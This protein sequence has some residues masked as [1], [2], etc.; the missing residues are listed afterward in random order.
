VRYCFWIRKNLLDDALQKA[1]NEHAEE[2][3]DEDLGFDAHGD[4]SKKRKTSVAQ[5]LARIRQNKPALFSDEGSLPAIGLQM[6][7]NGHRAIG[8]Y[9]EGRFLLRALSNGEGSGFNASTM[10]KLFNGSVWKRTVVKD[11]SRFSMHHTCLCLCMTFHIEEWHEFLS[12]DGALGMQSRFLTFHSSPRLDKANAVL[13]A[14]VYRGD[15]ADAPLHN[16][17]L[18]GRFV[19][20]LVYTD[21]AHASEKDYI[22]YYFAADALQYFSTH[23]DQQVLEQELSYLQ[24]PK[25]FSHARK[26]KSLPWRLAILL[27]SWRHACFQMG[28]ENAMWSRR[29]SQSVVKVSKT[30]FDYLSL[31][32][33]FLS[34]ASDLLQLLD[35]NSLRQQA[36]QKYPS[37]VSLLEGKS[38]PTASIPDPLSH[39]STNFPQW[40]DA[41]A[42]S[43]RLYCVVGAQW[44]LTSTSSLIVEQNALLRKLHDTE[45]GE[46]LAKDVARNHVINAFTLLHHAQLGFYIQK[47]S[48]HRVRK[49]RFPVEQNLALSFSNLLKVFNH[50]LAANSEQ[51]NQQHLNIT[52]SIKTAYKTDCEAAE[53]PLLDSG[54][55]DAV[56]QK[57]HD[58]CHDTSP[59]D[60]AAKIFNL[61]TKDRTPTI[62]GGS[63]SSRL[64]RLLFPASA[65]LLPV[66]VVANYLADTECR[67]LVAHA[68]L[69]ETYPGMQLDSADCD[70]IL[71]KLEN[72]APHLL[73][74]TLHIPE[75]VPFHCVRPPVSACVACSRVLAP[76]R[77]KVVPCIATLE[78]QTFVKVC[79]YICPQCHRKYCGPWIEATS[80]SG[81]E[82]RYLS[83]ASPTTFHTSSNILFAASFLDTVTNLLVNCGGSFRGIANSIQ[84]ASKTRHFETLLRDTWLQYS[85]T[86]FLGDESLSIDWALS[87]N[88]MEPLCRLLE[89]RITNLF[90][91]RWLHMHECSACSTGVLVVDGNAKVRTKLCANTD[92]GI[93]NCNLLK[94]H[95][96]TGCQNPPM[97]GKKYCCVHL[98]DS[99]PVL[100]SDTLMLRVLSFLHPA[101]PQLTIQA[102]C[103]LPCLPV[104]RRLC[105]ALRF[106]LVHA[107][108]SYPV[109]LLKVIKVSRSRKYFFQTAAGDSFSLLSSHVPLRFQQQFGASFLDPESRECQVKPRTGQQITFTDKEQ[110]KSCRA[111]WD[112]MTKARRSGG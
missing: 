47:G 65:D 57:L 90:Q 39:C 107:H 31:Q 64:D 50:K 80:A 13:D 19:D 89:P 3:D 48:G 63:T 92:D 60:S 112:R 10:S 20:V 109:D 54:S 40:W 28:N 96:L 5:A 15:D 34:P 83:T 66:F 88:R 98:R 101:A 95:C 61:K 87:N 24:D 30:I 97:P 71:Q 1:R 33:Q 104:C 111:Q 99:D 58:F 91:T 56:L 73:G 62:T 51:Y 108:G 93:W 49:R 81:R 100:G 85:L 6:S 75:Y 16:A 103:V 44:L 72:H 84:F 25:K 9:D 82:S 37:L 110:G 32:S 17:S 21:R 36:S 29:L 7:Q 102:Q 105:K 76:L 77:E 38:F 42:A 22:P 45:S 55:M 14:D 79:A 27:H 8:M 18:L 23:F 67:G 52:N 2:G 43:D 74:T 59:F 106:A 41:L 78:R 86:R 4:G 94:A 26:L 53:P 46:I 11:H 35:Q 12:K 70:F 68:M 69:R